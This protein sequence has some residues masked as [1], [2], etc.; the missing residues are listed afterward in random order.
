MVYKYSW[1]GPERAVSAEKVAHHLARIEQQYGEV[2]RENFLESARSETSEMHKLFEWDDTKAAHQYRLNQAS[3]IIASIR[4]TVVEKEPEQVKVRLYVQDKETSSGY[5]NIK[6]AFTEDDKR[7]RI[8]EEAKR[9]VE[10]FKN[11]Y[12][13]F[14]LFAKILKKFDGILDDLNELENG[15]GE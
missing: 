6:R 12:Q 10:W 9:D 8:I 2:T 14:V 4:V 7:K 3:V 1:S 13:G 11:K 5:V 15:G